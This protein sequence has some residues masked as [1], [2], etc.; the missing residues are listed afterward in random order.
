MF[1]SD[2][3]VVVGA[4]RGGPVGRDSIGRCRGLRPPLRALVLSPVKGGHWPLTPHR[5]QLLKCQGPGKWGPGDGWVGGCEKG[6]LV[7][8]TEYRPTLGGSRAPRGGEPR[9]PICGQEG[10]QHFPPWLLG[11]PRGAGPRT[12]I[13]Q[14]T[15]SV[16]RVHNGR[17]ASWLGPGLLA[18]PG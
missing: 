3:L 4:V 8:R 17:S 18:S 13:L 6:V 12:H 1:A 7:W 9:S 10:R 5:T 16:T 15:A 14:W 2:P 11:A